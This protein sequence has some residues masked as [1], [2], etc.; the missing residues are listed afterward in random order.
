[1]L[2][3]D[4]NE[5]RKDAFIYYRYVNFTE[6]FGEMGEH[7]KGYKKK[8]IIVGSVLAVLVLFGLVPVAYQAIV[9]QYLISYNL[10]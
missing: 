8:L 9:Y 5:N 1:M 2:D 3:G 4:S 7:G 10:H 6:E